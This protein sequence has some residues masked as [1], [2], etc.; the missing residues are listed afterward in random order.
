[1][2]N[3]KKYE[4]NFKKLSVQNE[5]AYEENKED[6]AKVVELNLE[7]VADDESAYA[8]S[9]DSDESDEESEMETIQKFSKS[10]IPMYRFTNLRTH[11]KNQNIV[12]SSTGTITLASKECKGLC[13][14]LEEKM[15]TLDLNGVRPLKNSI[16]LPQRK[17]MSFT[18]NEVM[19]IERDNEI[20]LRKIMAQQKT[21]KGKANIT[22]QKLSS[23]AINRKKSQRKIEED[24]MMLL[25]RLQKAK[26]C[27]L[28]TNKIPGFRVTQL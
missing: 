27:A 25:Q 7:D 14:T 2:D 15:S 28:N 20:L 9:F 19:K 13:L 8:D 4:P 17:N 26:S 16:L 22:L 24:N 10:E 6:D 18:N 23:S 5:I 11:T 12:T 3:L 21:R 1:M